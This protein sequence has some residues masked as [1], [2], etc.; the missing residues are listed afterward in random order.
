LAAGALEDA[1]AAFEALAEAAELAGAA[2]GA[3]SAAGVL[4]PAAAVAGLDALAAGAAAALFEPHEA[5]EHD[6]WPAAGAEEPAGVTSLAWT[7]GGVLPPQAARAPA[8]TV[9]RTAAKRSKDRF[10]RV[11]R[12]TILLR[13]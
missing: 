2:A 9:A 6:A 1:G 13:A 11:G 3:G 12:I 4:G 8:P 5:A 10:G 7:G